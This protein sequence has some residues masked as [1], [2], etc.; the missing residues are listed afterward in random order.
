MIKWFLG[1]RPIVLVTLPFII[2]G[3]VFMRFFL[4]DN[5]AFST[6]FGLWGTIDYYPL[7]LNF[8][9]LLTSLFFLSVS[10]SRIFNQN[11]FADKNTYISALSYVGLFALFTSFYWFTPVVICHLLLLAILHQ[12]FRLQQNSDARKIAFN[13]GLF[14][15]IAATC[16]PGLFV[17]LPFIYLMMLVIRPFV[18][19]ELLLILIG[20]SV[21][22]I[23]L[24]LY[25]WINDV[26]VNFEFSPPEKTLDRFPLEKLVTILFVGILL[27]LSIFAVNGSGF[28]SSIRSKRLKSMLFWLCLPLS[29]LGVYEFLFYGELIQ[30]SFLVIPLTLL[31]SMAFFNNKYKGLMSVSTYILWVLVFFK[32]L[33]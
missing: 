20:F 21:P 14:L 30:L 8:L 4:Q 24:L 33:L 31:I 26:P 27:L 5:T 7:W 1:N 10:M 2:I 15:G 13:S 17:V 22:F 6:T 23:Y 19:R 29:A 9:L 32:L 25:L 3:L 11:A 12:L 28:K 16:A 18:L